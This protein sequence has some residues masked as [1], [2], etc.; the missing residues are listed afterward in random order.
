MNRVFSESLV[1]KTWFR[2]KRMAMYFSNDTLTT[3]NE[4]EE[5]RTWQSL[6]QKDPLQGPSH[7]LPQLRELEV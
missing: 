1:R 7:N 3:K 6:D 5:A 4:E 2:E